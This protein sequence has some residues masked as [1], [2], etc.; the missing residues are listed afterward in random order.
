[1]LKKLNLMSK[2]EL[3]YMSSYPYHI[4]DTFLSNWN[5]IE[6]YPKDYKQILF[7]REHEDFV[8][9]EDITDYDDT[10]RSFKENNRFCNNNY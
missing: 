7:T 5:G 8:I 6:E 4:I 10:Q 3:Y 2:V 1:M 9:W